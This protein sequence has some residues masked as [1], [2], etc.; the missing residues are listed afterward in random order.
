V[1]L[2]A[3][4]VVELGAVQ[5]EDSTTSQLKNLRS[6]ELTPNSLDTLQNP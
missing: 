1:K 6:E 4:E 5:F 2:L 3:C